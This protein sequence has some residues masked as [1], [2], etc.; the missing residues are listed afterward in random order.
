MRPE[1]SQYQYSLYELKLPYCTVCTP[2]LG[3]T[4]TW[5]TPIT[6]VESSNATYSLWFTTQD[7]PTVAQPSASISG[8]SI[9][10]SKIFK[11]VTS[12][13]ES[14]PLIK[15]GKGMSSRSTISLSLADFD[16]DPGPINFSDEGSFFGKLLARNVLD[17]K[18]LKV[19]NYSI[20]D[21]VTYEVSTAIYFIESAQ[22]SNSQIKITGKDALK[23]IEAFGQQVPEPSIVT[24]TSDINDSTTTIPV[25]DGSY[26]VAGDRFVIG[27]EIFRVVSVS[28]NT[29]TSATRGEGLTNGDGTTVY[30][31]TASEH[32]SGD[33]VQKGILYNK[34]FLSNA[35]QDIYD[36][37]GLSAYVDFTQWDDEIS[38]WS[39]SAFLYGIITEP[40][41]AIDLIDQMLQVY[42]VD[43]WLD[44]DSQK[45]IVS[46]VSA[47]KQ[48]IRTISE[49]NDIQKLKI[50]TQPNQRFSRSYITHKKPFQA[51]SDDKENYT[52][53]T[54][55]TDVATEVSD[56]YGSVKLFEFDPCPWISDS[57]A[58]QLVSRFVQ[59]FSDPPRELTFNIEERKL[60]DT[61][62]GDVVD[63]I[64]R[65]TQL[66]DGTEYG[67]R[68]TAQITQLKP[69]VNGI[70]R[71]YAAKA[72]SY[73]PL[74]DT[75][76]GPLVIFI[77]GTVFD[78]NLYDRAGAPNAAVDVTFVLQGA[79]VGSSDTPYAMRAGGFASGST[80][81][82]ICTES[83]IWS[84]KGG[85]GGDVRVGRTNSFVSQGGSG[86]NSYYADGI[87]TSIYLNYGTV[88]T[89]V[90]DSTFYA[91]GGGA[92]SAGV[93]KRQTSG[94]ITLFTFH[95]SGGGGGSG[96]PGGIGGNAIEGDAILGN[97]E[98]L[99][100]TNGSFSTA[101]HGI[102]SSLLLA[103]GGD[104]GFS[105]NGIDNGYASA[106]AYTELYFEGY[107]ST[108]GAAGFGITGGVS[109]ATVTVYNLA[110]SSSKLRDGSSVAGVDYTLVTV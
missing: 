45:V 110:A 91:A 1:F 40:T 105:L 73:I 106:G 99:N 68:I 7:A 89:Y 80:I 27:D 39:S 20:A 82:I 8:K 58:T 17:G 88:D 37:V 35:L 71:M 46:A 10:N 34:V 86:D 52:K 3:V 54:T 75:G 81:K 109:A 16:G 53:Y 95:A 22:I 36:D 100:G 11:C 98:Y 92:G 26:L 72:L 41:E 38:E 48:A 77:S 44:Q 9:L 4:G 79:T 96:I 102:E 63:I 84:A 21:G 61:K 47:W 97:R 108:V 78:L 90:T 13:S 25:T 51:L 64:S 103:E 85:A 65:D 19:Y 107:N 83:T 59:R 50:K 67:A 56:L 28:V 14:T 29:I 104:G 5:H 31:T 69:I 60:L 55:Y 6:C 93:G 76:G 74:I 62:L 42:Q 33:T 101:G 15:P 94:I 30:E 70:G 43:M 32:A 12:A 24:L 49:L 66:P 23:D 18:E 87:T 2:E 57:S